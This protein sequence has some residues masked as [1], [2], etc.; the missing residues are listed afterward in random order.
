MSFLK[1]IW[2]F[3]T[4]GDFQINY[5]HYYTEKLSHE[6]FKAIWNKN[7]EEMKID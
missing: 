6:E 3:L 2:R 4:C 5:E 1:R 7:L